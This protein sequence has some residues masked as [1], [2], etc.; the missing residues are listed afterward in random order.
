MAAQ[1]PWA[2]AY[3]SASCGFMKVSPTTTPHLYLHMQQ[4]FS[5]PPSICPSSIPS[6]PPPA[7]SV[8]SPSQSAH[9]NAYLAHFV[10]YMVFFLWR[11]PSSPPVP[12]D[13]T[14]RTFLEFRQFTSR[15]L[16]STSPNVTSTVVL[17]SLKY[18]H[19]LRRA[20]ARNNIYPEPRSEFRIW[21]TSIMLADAFHND[22]AFTTKS[23]SQ[24]SG[25]RTNECATMQREFLKWIDYS[26]VITEKQYAEWI[27]YMERFLSASAAARGESS[28]GMGVGMGMGGG[29]EYEWGTAAMP[30]PL[31][32]YATPMHTSLP[33]LHTAV[34]PHTPVHEQPL[35]RPFYLDPNRPRSSYQQ[36]LQTRRLYASE[37]PRMQMSAHPTSASIA[38][39]T[40]TST[41]SSSSDWQQP[42]YAVYHHPAQSYAPVTQSYAPITTSMDSVAMLTASMDSM[43][44]MTAATQ[45]P[46]SSSSSSYPTSSIA[47][48]PPSSV[49]APIQINWVQPSWD[50]STAKLPMSMSLGT[51]LFNAGMYGNF[52]DAVGG[53]GG[54][55]G[56]GANGGGGHYVM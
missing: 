12:P 3:T 23:W 10:A 17:I 20:L 55:G 30:S 34:T 13:P 31:D 16:Q 47:S 39:T 37:V 45:P 1:Q 27:K 2:P 52:G 46:V 54:Y 25:F 53:Q 22:N 5:A 24:V 42:T 56:A 19:R 32:G 40:S 38:S 35:F 44:M 36:P 26:L 14:S 50:Y 7:Y 11:P 21:A 18:I 33:S 49:S 4:A 51:E 6:D 28:L 43:A 8:T 9:N 48:Y 15:V 41:S 29:M